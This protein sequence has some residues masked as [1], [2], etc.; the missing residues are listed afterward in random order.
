MVYMPDAGAA[1][2]GP[3]TQERKTMTKEVV[4]C[5]AVRTPVGSF[6]GS[7]APM[8]AMELGSLTITEA[9]KRAGVAPEQVDEV[10][11][12]HVLQAG[13]GQNSARQA[14]MGAGIPKEVPAITINKVCG[15]GLKSVGMAMQSILAGDNDIVVA[16]G[17]ESMSN[18]PYLLAKART[19]Y[20][21]GDDKVIDEMIK[22]GL[23]DAFNQYHMGI[24]AENVA[25][26][27]GVN[28]DMQDAFALR[29]QQRAVAAIESGAFKDEIVPVTIKTRKGEVV[30][31]T[32]EYPRKDASLDSLTKLK[33]A[34]KKDGTVTA[35][36]A[37]GINDG[38]A[39]FVLASAEKAKEL[40]LKP[41][42]RVLS[43]SSA[44][45]DPATMGLGPIPA[46]KKA[47]A[48]AG[49]NLDAIDLIEANEAFAAQCLAVGN[50]FSFPDEKLN[51][52]GGAIALGHPIGASGCR[53]LVTLLYEMQRRDVKKG[54]VTLCVGGG[55]GIALTVER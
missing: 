46:V 30:V 19:G 50:E 34:F 39:A 26:Q 38:A 24:T 49:V 22:D 3:G 47:L 27:C 23:W 5:S 1:M 55:Q 54:L 8:S 37:S 18:A 4:I 43:V 41:L 45:V 32:D 10:I 53:I 36:N 52:N 11:F 7:L 12:G 20:R 13:C 40:G 25:E 14:S 48:R 16:G 21:M 33:P 44:G 29:S 28:R 6:N 51:V 2:R 31:D 35:G 15:S 42:A 17:M 9:L